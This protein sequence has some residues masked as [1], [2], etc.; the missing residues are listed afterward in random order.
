MRHEV[1]IELAAVRVDAPN[2]VGAEEVALRLRQR[3]PLVVPVPRTVVLCE[4]RDRAV[5]VRQDELDPLVEPG[6]AE[7]LESS[8]V[9]VTRTKWGLS[10]CTRA[11]C[12]RY[13][14]YAG[15][16]A[17]EVGGMTLG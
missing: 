1:D 6:R 7:V 2:G 13:G 3:A 5:A 4:A 15:R 8:V 14:R 17:V 9:K 11:I 16:T 10:R 12:A